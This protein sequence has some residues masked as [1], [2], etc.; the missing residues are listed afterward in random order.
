MLIKVHPCIKFT[1]TQ[2]FSLLFPILFPTFFPI[3]ILFWLP[4]ALNKGKD[5]FIVSMSSLKPKL[6]QKKQSKSP[7][8]NPKVLI[9]F[10]KKQKS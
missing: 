6:L 9:F 7:P 10:R 4:D 3:K 8:K 1:P 5:F 2:Y